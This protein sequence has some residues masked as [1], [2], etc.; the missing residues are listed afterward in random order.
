M[1]KTEKLNEEQIFMQEVDDG[2]LKTVTGGEVC[3]NGQW[4]EKDRNCTKMETRR[5]Y[6]GKGFPNCAAT[7]EEG[8]WCG[9][10]DAC[11]WKAVV[12][13]D[14]KRCTNSFE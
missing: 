10:N 13:T 4:F 6:G 1:S 8:S 2:E 11:T 7:V 9:Y 5:I 3:E 14:T 12:Y